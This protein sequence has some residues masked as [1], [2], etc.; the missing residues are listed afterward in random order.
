MQVANRMTANLANW[1][2]WLQV[3]CQWD[4][5]KM[6]LGGRTGVG[7]P[8]DGPEVHAGCIRTLAYIAICDP[9]DLDP[10]FTAEPPHEAQQVG[11]LQA[12]MPPDSMVRALAVAM[13]PSLEH[14][15][16]AF[17]ALRKLSRTGGFGTHNVP[18]EAR[19]SA[20]VEAGIRT[21]GLTSEVSLPMSP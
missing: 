6:N 7:G 15:P 4:V 3:V 9:R 11:Q 21:L 12:L 2:V 13:V 20:W 1:S 18:T 19:F 8:A 10:A 14:F 17:A 5:D 16:R